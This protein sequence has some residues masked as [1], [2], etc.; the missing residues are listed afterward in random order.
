MYCILPVLAQNCEI[1]FPGTAS[2]TFSGS[3]GGSTVSNLE[4]G[5]NINMGDGDIFTFNVP[6]VNITGNLHVDADG[7]G[8]IIIPAGV[9]VN[10]SGNFQLH[11]K[12]G[13]C[14]SANPC[15][16]EIVVNGYANFTD[17]VDNDIF[18]L[19]WS[20][21]GT[22]VVGDKFKNSSNACMDCGVGGCPT[23]QINPSDCTD[24]GSGCSNGDFCATIQ[25]PCL[26]DVTDPVITGC[27]SNR[28]IN[29]TGPGCT[30]PVSWVAP[31]AS[32]NCA[33]TS[34]TASHI[35]G[36]AF[37]KGITVVTYT[38]TD[39]A[40]NI[41]TCSFNV[42]VVDNLA[43]VITGCPANITVNANASCQAVVSWTAPAFTD[44]CAGGTLTST[45][46]PGSTFSK[47]I[48]T[49]IYTA[50]D[51]AGNTATCSFNV[52][53]VDNAAPVITGCPANITVN[54]N[55]SCQAVVSWT[56]PAFTDNCAGGTLTTTKAPGST[57]S[58]GITTVI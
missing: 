52:D 51:A 54:A 23:I 47:G 11:S 12:N 21:T 27:P 26:S 53:V 40:G 29:M 28:T 32:D 45:K 50:T 22:V 41:A 31:T 13:Q 8:K 38:A 24:D 17:D 9:T 25:N 39:A 36:T 48:T 33:V 56:A 58:K 15:V 6:T 55:A 2:R 30:Q 20:G 10:L 5:K 49:V 16:F 19:I 14:T 4:L 35:S 1:D 43:P 18:T 46:A 44:N 42:D 34:F 37:P 57:F 3:C 7:D